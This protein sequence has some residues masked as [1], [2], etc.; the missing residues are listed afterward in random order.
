M[1]TKGTVHLISRT[2]QAFEVGDSQGE[3][4]NVLVFIGGLT[5]GLMTVRY[6][7]MLDVPAGWTVF[8]IM[9]SSSYSGWGMGSLDRDVEEIDLLVKHLRT[10]CNKKKV[11]LMG[12]STGTQDSLHYLLKKDSVDGIILQASVSDREAL[13][14]FMGSDGLE[15]MNEKALKMQN[16]NGSSCVLPRYY[17]DAFFEA[18]IS[19]YRWL[20]L[21]TVNGD[22]DYFSSDLSDERLEGTFGKI[23]KPVLILYSG[24]DEYVPPHVDKQKLLDRWL[25]FIPHGMASPEC[26]VVPGATHRIVDGPSPELPLQVMKSSVYNFLCG[27]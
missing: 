22:D 17:S 13:T 12:H 21:A 7:S 5:D 1:P 26:K 9:F 15:K 10:K 25:S 2:V 20:S 6:V 16:E 23:N 4:E 14:M 8:N 18:P 27:I 3:N 24:Q 11:V 19:C